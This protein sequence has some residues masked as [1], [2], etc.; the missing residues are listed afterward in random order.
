MELNQNHFPCIEGLLSTKTQEIALSP[1]LGNL[2][3]KNL[4]QKKKLGK[5]IFTINPNIFYLYE[6]R[7]LG[8]KSKNL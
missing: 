7:I 6:I 1:V 4:V 8:L 3:L 2:A 5:V